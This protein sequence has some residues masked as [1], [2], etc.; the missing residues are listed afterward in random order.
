M[1]IELRVSERL[2]LEMIFLPIKLG[3][4]VTAA[5]TVFQRE[6]FTAAVGVMEHTT[7]IVSRCVV[8]VRRSVVGREVGLCI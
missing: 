6:I 4:R 1:G 7:V 2:T 8:S 5:D 3:L